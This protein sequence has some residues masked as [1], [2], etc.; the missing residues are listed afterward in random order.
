MRALTGAHSP[1][2]GTVAP[3]ATGE[4]SIYDTMVTTC[5]R[6]GYVVRLATEPRGWVIRVYDLAGAEACHTLVGD[7]KNLD[8][9]AVSILLYLKPLLSLERE[10]A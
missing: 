5:T 1:R 2:I 7:K 6:H 9:G 3:M 4:V 8:S 10:P